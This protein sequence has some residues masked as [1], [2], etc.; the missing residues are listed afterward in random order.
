MTFINIYSPLVFHLAHPRELKTYTPPLS[1]LS[2][3]AS[4]LVISPGEAHLAHPLELLYRVF[5]TLTHGQKHGATRVEMK[6]SLQNVTTNRTQAP[7]PT[8][9]KSWSGWE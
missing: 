6:I 2:P 5:Y 7:L 4:P 1:S 9:A 8:S 3:T